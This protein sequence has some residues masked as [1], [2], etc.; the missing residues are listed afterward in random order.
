MPSRSQLLQ[1]THSTHNDEPPSCF[2]RSHSSSPHSVHAN[3]LS[4][5]TTGT[6]KSRRVA[7]K[8]AGRPFQ[9]P[10]IFG[11]F[12]QFRLVSVIRFLRFQCLSRLSSER[13]PLSP[14]VHQ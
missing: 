14:F 11:F 10:R 13:E 3:P 7:A 2:E 5:P 1:Q 6:T 8:S 12:R 4:T 9:Q